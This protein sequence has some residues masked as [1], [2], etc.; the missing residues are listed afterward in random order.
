MRGPMTLILVACGGPNNGSQAPDGSMYGDTGATNVDP[1]T[2]YINVAPDVM[3]TGNFTG[4]VPGVSWDTTSWLT[5]NVDPALVVDHSLTGL[6]EDFEK[7]TPVDQATVTFW[8]DDVFD[9]SPDDV[10][11]SDVNGF[12]YTTKSACK[13]LTYRVTTDP[14]LAETKTTFE[15]HQIFGAPPG[16]DIGDAEFLSVSSTTYQLIPTLLGVT[17]DPDKA[18]VAGTAFDVL[19]DGGLQ[20]DDD[21]G[22]IAG[23]QVI[24]YDENGNI[25][26]SLVVNYFLEDFPH[27]DQKYTSPDGLWV[28]SNVPPGKLRVEL[29]GNLNGALTLLGATL[30]HSEA[31][32][33]NVSNIYSG[34]GEGVKYPNTCLVP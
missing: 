5:Q 31:N 4:F 17:V 27:R 23:A 34:F 7:D 6:V 32:S 14:V 30:V 29:W 1:F 3:V 15:A 25:P 10:Q 18:I 26:E 19:R 22:K 16:P 24:V 21:T 13:P 8:D 12:V 11:E 33:I 20:S 28:A 2:K 9:T